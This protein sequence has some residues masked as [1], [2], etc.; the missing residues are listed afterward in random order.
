[1]IS[2]SNCNLTEAFKAPNF[3]I[4]FMSVWPIVRFVTLFAPESRQSFHVI[5]NVN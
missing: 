4:D 1:M 5:K 2:Y 3:E